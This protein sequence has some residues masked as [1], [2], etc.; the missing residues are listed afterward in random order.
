MTANRARHWLSFWAALALLAAAAGAAAQ[1]VVRPEKAYPYRVEAEGT[2]LLVKFDLLDGYYLYRN[3]F[4]FASKTEGI[5]LGEPV[6]PRG[7]THEDQ[8][9]GKQE[10]YRGAFE[11]A[12]PYT[13]AAGSAGSAA[14]LALEVRLQGCADVGLCYPPQTWTRE[15]ELPPAAPLSSAAPRQTPIEPRGAPAGPGTASPFLPGASAPALPQEEAFVMNARFDAANELTVGWQIQ[16]GYYLYRDKLRVEADGDIELGPP[17]MPAGQVFS[18]ESFGDVRIFR[19]YV[20]VKVPFAR[21]SAGE[22][23]V[24]IRGAYQGCKDG[25]LCYPPSEQTMAMTVPAADSFAADSFAAGSSGA[26]SAG[27]ATGAGGAAASSAGPLSE[28]D[29]LIARAIS[30]SWLVMLGLFY[31]AG[32]GLAFTPCVLPMVPIVSSIIAG[33]GDLSAK[34]GFALSFSYVMGMAVTYTVAGALAALVGQQ[35]QAVFQKPWIIALFAGVFV[36][37]GLSMFG[38][39]NLQVPAAIQT[40]VASLANRQ[41]AGSFIGTGVMGALSALIVTTC[42][43]PALVAALALIGQ[44]GDVA[45]GAAALFAL[46]LGMGSPLLLVGASAGTLLPKVGAWMNTV[47]A[48]FGVMLLGLAIWMLQRVIPGGIA[49]V[50]W[51]LLVFLTGVFLGAFE[52]LPQSPGGVRRLAKGLGVLACLYGAL[53]LI[54]ATLGGTSPLQPIPRGAI[55]GGATVAAA[56]AEEPA[57]QA[58]DSVPQLEAALAAARESGR[59][60]LVDFTADWCV[61]C[62]EMEEYTFPD[63]DVAAALAGFTLL[64]ADVTA[65]DDD[66]KALLKYFNSF[67]PPTMAFFDAHG[68]QQDRYRLV[69]YVAPEKFAEHVRS[70]AAL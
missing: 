54:G 34:R 7:Q 6:Y 5:S 20:E 13:R 56:R 28:Q 69:G 39:F 29:R 45:R 36:L 8:Y 41:R 14:K 33:Q 50:L 1:D 17:S 9:F 37:L 10:I 66:D 52:P 18:D 43:A 64:R 15:V 46:S 2:R 31:V 11:I 35:I 21:A 24:T 32:L 42:V 61:S 70:L 63:A 55:G 58:I 57:F 23:P 67:G 44:Q 4:G 53:M 12:I 27:S 62:K 49:L 26:A 3:R 51:S 60:V 65:N 59:P 30:G 16:P 25:S 47:K 38:L 68:V 22:I 19:D 48:A 40:R